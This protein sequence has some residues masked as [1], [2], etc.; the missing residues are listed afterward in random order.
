[1][2]ATTPPA[3]TIV[4]TSATQAILPSTSE[5]M[6]ESFSDTTVP[7]SAIFGDSFTMRAVTTPTEGGSAGA[8]CAGA[9]VAASIAASA[10]QRAVDWKEVPECLLVTSRRLPRWC[11]GSLTQGYRLFAQSQHSWHQNQGKNMADQATA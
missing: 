2:R 7:G 10:A 4:P 6:W 9:D 8:C 5:A 3:G 1:M 11:H